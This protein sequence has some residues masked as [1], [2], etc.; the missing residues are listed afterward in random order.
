MHQPG[1][2]PMA[3]FGTDQGT[4]SLLFTM[5]LFLLRVPCPLCL[6]Q[7]GHQPERGGGWGRQ[8]DFQA[9]A[10]GVAI[11]GESGFPPGK[12]GGLGKGWQTG[13][14]TPAKLLSQHL[15]SIRPS[16]QGVDQMC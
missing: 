10:P 12:L 16:A 4:N 14:G 11:A 3:S 7:N 13:R 1:P 5:S 8:E 6:V 2:D 15:C 9:W